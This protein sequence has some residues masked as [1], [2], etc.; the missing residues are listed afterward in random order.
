MQVGKELLEPSAVVPSM[1]R[2]ALWLRGW[3]ACMATAR[4]LSLGVRL[5]QDGR[6]ESTILDGAPGS[7][8]VH[9]ACQ[10]SVLRAGAPY[11]DISWRW[12]VP[13]QLSGAASPACLLQTTCP[14][15]IDGGLLLPSLCV[16]L[17]RPSP[18]RSVPPSRPP[19]Y[20]I[21]SAKPLSPGDRTS[22]FGAHNST[23]STGCENVEKEE[24]FR[25]TLGGPEGGGS[26]PQLS[27]GPVEEVLGWHGSS[28]LSPAPGS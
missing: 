10:D 15:C 28:A 4:L 2:S 5:W 14:W 12:E 18:V 3:G 17:G 21:A 13:G 22:A 6:S 11:A 16:L 25:C 26:K 9:W 23:H 7:P 19:L 8:L 1:L 20:L 24:V 27:E